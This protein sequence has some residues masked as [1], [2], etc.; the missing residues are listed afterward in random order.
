MFAHRLSYFGIARVAE[1][2]VYAMDGRWI[3]EGYGVEPTIEVENLP[4][5]TYL[6][7]DAQLDA[8]IQY[9]Q[10]KMEQE[11]IPEVIP[12]PFPNVGETAEEILN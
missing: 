3:V 10:R 8:A 6:G 9:L 4:H 11:P 7:N 5:A 1:F 12:Q 2:P